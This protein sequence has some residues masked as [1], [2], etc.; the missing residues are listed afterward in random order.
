MPRRD[1]LLTLIAVGVVCAAAIVSIFVHEEEAHQHDA[2]PRGEPRVQLVTRPRA[3]AG[4]PE[5]PMTPAPPHPAVAAIPDDWTLAIRDESGSPLA[6]AHVVP[7]DPDIASARS[8]QSGLASLVMAGSADWS[9]LRAVVRRDGFV[10]MDIAPPAE[11]ESRREHQVVT[12]A[13]SATISGRVHV[14][15]GASGV[16][17]ARVLAW[18]TSSA[19][20]LST[21]IDGHRLSPA[22]EI[23]TCDATGS[24][25]LDE[26]QPG[27]EYCIIAA[28][29]GYVTDSDPPPVLVAGTQGVDLPLRRIYAAVIELVDTNGA[30]VRRPERVGTWPPPNITLRG[31]NAP[32]TLLS[33]SALAASISGDT[34][35]KRQVELPR[36][37]G[38]GLSWLFASSDSTLESIGPI[39]FFV[40]VPGYRPIKAEI[41]AFPLRDPVDVNR[42]VMTG[43]PGVQRGSVEITLRGTSTSDDATQRIDPAVVV[44]LLPERTGED[45]VEVFEIPVMQT[46]TSIRIDGIPVG[47]YRVVHDWALPMPPSSA[48]TCEIVAGTITPLEVG[49]AD[50]SMLA[51]RVSAEP[52]APV[53]GPLRLQIGWRISDGRFV[54]HDVLFQAPPYVINHV[55][56]GTYS[57]SGRYGGRELVPATIDI[58]GP[59]AEITVQLAQ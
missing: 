2:T 29:R 56:P 50:L 59:R 31:L 30:P 6:S 1:R 42:I 39:L 55:P 3:H 17:G 58:R 57:L 20:P 8:D 41:L 54:S 25:L 16:P 44:K 40:N 13:R 24:F 7:N 47:R 43:I 45:G 19:P 26:L 35:L 11:A 5:P 9:R 38:G 53:C 34:E 51:V 22:T 46:S 21:A 49:R 10:P 14:G 15:D 23:A 37:P 27:Q 48:T 52:T 33:A 28:A 18:A 12:L 4:A 36:A 32:A